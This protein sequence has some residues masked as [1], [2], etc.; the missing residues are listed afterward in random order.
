VIKS[1]TTILTERASCIG[2]SRSEYRDFVG[3][4]KRTRTL[5][6]HRCRW[7]VV[8]RMDLQ[9]IEWEGIDWIDV[10]QDRDS[11]WDVVN[12]VLKIRCP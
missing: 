8:I 3:K 11:L 6:R 9:E 7:E 12:T 10:A 5:G 4:P 2:E 1:R